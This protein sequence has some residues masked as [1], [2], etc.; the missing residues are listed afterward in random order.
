M[1]YT[2]LLIFLSAIFMLS[3]GSEDAS[4]ALPLT[5]S[6]ALYA[7]TIAGFWLLVKY[8]FNKPATNHPNGYFKAEKQLSIA[9]LACFTIMI[10]FGDIKV[11]AAGLPLHTQLPM[12]SDIFGLFIFFTYLFLIWIVGS[13]SYA[14]A[15]SKPRKTS[16]FVFTNFKFNLPIILPWIGLSL[17]YDLL[18]LIPSEQLSRL[19]ESFWGDMLFLGLFVLLVLFL[20]PPIVRRLWGCTPFPEGPLKN[21]LDSFCSNL[22]F[23]ADLYLW[24]L[25]EGRVLTAGV[26]GLLPGLRYVMFTPALLQNLNHFELEAVMAHEIGHV[27][28]KHLLLY[29][30]LIGGFS[31]AAGLLAEPILYGVLSMDW[32]YAV[33]ARDII[34]TE[35]LISLISGIPLLILLLVYFRYIFGYFIRNFERQAD[36]FAF[37]TLGSSRGLIS[38]FQKI[39]M[40]SGQNADKPN[41]HHFGVGERIACL[42]SCEQNPSRVRTQ[43]RKVRRSLFAYVII[44]AFCIVTVDRIPS[45]QLSRTYEGRYIESVLMPNIKGI[46]NEAEWFRMLGDLLQGRGLDGKALRAYHNALRLEPENHETLNNLAWLLLTCQDPNLRDPVR[47]L[48]LAH[49]AADHAPLPHVLD[50]LATA[51]W[52]NGNVEKAITTEDRALRM[53]PRQE[54][55]YRLQLERF[56]TSI[57]SKDTEFIN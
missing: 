46:E 40:V 50:T 6:A 25:Y 13:K 42:G 7:G 30:F 16:S 45:D 56:K 33:M 28:H 53:D 21:H 55:F 5:G 12:L 10:F 37:K 31:I 32:I 34:S 41:W 18:D 4:T 36:L 35:T 52:A 51:Y 49:S 44:L 17:M 23:K 57:Y 48:D 2:N 3:L 1:I 47:A 9:A 8:R 11:H 54:I 39:L 20:F 14:S 19:L 22:N 24:P 27:K 29:I 26:M 15:F 43:D 38:A